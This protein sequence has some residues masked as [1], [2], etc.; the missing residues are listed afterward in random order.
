MRPRLPVRFRPAR[1]GSFA[2][3][4]AAGGTGG[5][6][7]GARAA[8]RLPALPP[9]YQPAGLARRWVA[10]ALDLPLSFIFTFGWVAGVVLFLFLLDALLDLE[11]LRLLH[12]GRNPAQTAGLFL[13]LFALPYT[14]YF[15]LPL[16]RVGKT[17][18]FFFAHIRMIPDEGPPLPAGGRERTFGRP[19]LLQAF[20]AVLPDLLAGVA[21]L[22]FLPDATVTPAFAG[23]LSTI[24]LP[25]ASTLAFFILTQF[26]D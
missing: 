19:G 10:Y 21:A 17:A 16:H 12:Y 1:R 7:E 6:K 25:I 9:L 2:S 22:S 23:L 14:G 8:L 15:V 26:I 3:P 4:E 18:G 5:A 20:V 24:R 11:I 13:G